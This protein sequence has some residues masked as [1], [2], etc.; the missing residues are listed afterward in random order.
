MRAILSVLLVAAVATSQTAAAADAAEGAIVIRSKDREAA[1]AGAIVIRNSA[2]LPEPA[3]DEPRRAADP[4]QRV[5]AVF[6]YEPVAGG[7]WRGAV[8]HGRLRASPSLASAVVAS[9][10]KGDGL[11]VV[12]KLAG[13]PWYVVD[14]DGRLVFAHETVLEPPAA[15]AQGGAFVGLVPGGPCP[16]WK[17]GVN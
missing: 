10:S 3:A 15:A 5:P 1:P 9:F 7:R 11:S 4:V 17:C 2:P 14:L 16:A 8:E 13:E 12:G 6:E